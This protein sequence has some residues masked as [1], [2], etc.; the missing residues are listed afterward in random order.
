MSSTKKLRQNTVDKFSDFVGKSKEFD[1]TEVPTNRAVI[2]RGLLIKEKHFLELDKAKLEIHKQKIAQELSALVLAQ[3]QKSN[4]KF[5]PPVTIKENS[6]CKRIEK[7]WDRV[8]KVA[9][10]HAKKKEVET[11]KNL[12]DKVLVITTCNHTIML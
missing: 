8:M 9:W 1:K 10:G 4:A 5:H 11:V 12:L 3:W 2:Q 6:L 7:L